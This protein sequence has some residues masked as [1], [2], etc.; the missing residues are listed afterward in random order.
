M[1]QNVFLGDGPFGS[2][3]VAVLGQYS[4][5]VSYPGVGPSTP[6]MRASSLQPQPIYQRPAQPSEARMITRPTSQPMAV[7]GSDVHCYFCE[8]LPDAP[9][10][11]MSEAQAAQWNKDRDARCNQ[12]NS[13]ECERKY[14]QMQAQQQANL[15]NFNVINFQSSTTYAPVMS[16]RIPVQN[17]GLVG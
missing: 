7:G 13:L 8:N 11:W 2:R 3:Q 17:P 15:R 12:V 9:T 10:Y 14:N 1:R 6:F 4:Y 16:G 5:P